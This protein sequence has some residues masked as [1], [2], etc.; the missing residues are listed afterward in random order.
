MNFRHNRRVY[1]KVTSGGQESHA[2]NTHIGV[3]MSLHCQTFYR[4]PI[5]SLRPSSGPVVYMILL[6]PSQRLHVDRVTDVSEVHASGSEEGMWAHRYWSGRPPIR[7]LDKNAIKTALLRAT[8]C[9]IT[10]S[11]CCSQAVNQP[12]DNPAKCRLNL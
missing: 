12:S 3:L 6:L 10:N 11:N 5:A 8:K 4:Y 9:T 1:V 7:T 2:V